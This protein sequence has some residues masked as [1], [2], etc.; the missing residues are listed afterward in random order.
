MDNFEQKSVLFFVA[1]D[2]FEEQFCKPQ[3]FMGQLRQ[4]VNAACVEML[5]IPVRFH[6][7][8]VPGYDAKS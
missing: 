2:M 3:H 5:F 1:K 7:F 8:R 4:Q 6:Q